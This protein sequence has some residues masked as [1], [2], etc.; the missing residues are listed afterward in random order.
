MVGRDAEL[1][2]LRARLGE[3]AD[4]HPVA[5]LIGGDAG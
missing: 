2:Q 1:A 3:A 5:A 4:G